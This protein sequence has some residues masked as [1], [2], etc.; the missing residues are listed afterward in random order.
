MGEI[1][2]EF[3]LEERFPFTRCLYDDLILLFENTQITID[4]LAHHEY[5]ERY[6][7]KRNQ[8]NV[9]I[10]FGYKMNGFFGRVVP[11]PSQTNSNALLSDI[12]GK[13]QTF[14]KGEYAC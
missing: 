6:T 5:R 12:Q 1:G 8:D 14:T 13:L 10:D 7:F 9:V 2:F 11:I 4:N 3:D